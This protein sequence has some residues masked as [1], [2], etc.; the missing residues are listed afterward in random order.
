MPVIAAPTQERRRSA[1]LEPP[2]G[3]EVS[4]LRPDQSLFANSVNVSRGG[5]CLRLQEALEVRS[6]V[7]LQFTQAVRTVTCLGR[8][9]W[10]I[11]RLDLREGPPFLFDIGIEFVDPPPFLRQLMARQGV[12]SPAAPPRTSRGRVVETYAIRA[13]QYVSRLERTTDR[14]LRW[15]LV[16]SVEGTPCFS[17]R[18]HS[19]RA[20]LVAWGRFKRQQGKP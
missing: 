8:V 7:R 16:I 20:A 14:P 13:R 10:V 9:S 12:R 2:A 18:Y 3:F 11:Q 1:R 4:L 19:E 17:H 15:H 6:L 5:L